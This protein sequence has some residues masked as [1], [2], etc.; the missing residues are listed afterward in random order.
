MAAFL[1]RALDLPPT[2]ENVFQ[3]GDS[4]FEASINRLGASGI[5]R[6]CMGG[7]SFCADQPVSRGQMA[8]FLKRAL[9]G[10]LPSGTHPDFLDTSESIFRAN[11]QWLAGTGVTQGC[12]SPLNTLFGPA[13]FV[14]RGQMAAFPVEHWTP[15][16]ADTL[17]PTPTVRMA[18][19]LPDQNYNHYRAYL[20][21]HSHGLCIRC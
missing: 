21:H 9:E 15:R 1:D 20:L 12:N 4:T 18:T 10:V 8:A 2:S 19:N 7:T 16:S 5:T 13:D 17:K 11:V 6:G 14:A 3:D